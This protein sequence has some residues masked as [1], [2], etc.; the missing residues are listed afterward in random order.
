MM[1]FWAGV[2]VGV[3]SG[4]ILGVLAV[5]LMVMAGR[6]AQAEAPLQFIGNGGREGFRLPKADCL[7]EGCPLL[8]GTP[9]RPV[10]RATSA[11]RN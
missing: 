4:G 11:L 5:S 3:L 8:M 2:G 6:T 10:V 9:R 7:A 1:L